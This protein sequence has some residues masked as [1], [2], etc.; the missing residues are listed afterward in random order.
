MSDIRLL[1]DQLINRIAAGEVVERPASVLKELMENS[2]DAGATRLEV[3][4]EN[5]GR[6]LVAV[7]D[8]GRGMGPDDLL[9]AVERHATSKLAEESDLLNID[10]LGF[11]GEALPSIGAVSR[12]TITS[13]DGGDG[14]GRRARISGGRLLGVDDVARD[15]GTTVEAAD[16]FFNVPARRKF[17]KSTATEAAHCLE[18]VQRFAI[19]RP[20]LRLIYRHNRQEMLST[21]P[22]EDER[23]RLARVLGRDTARSLIPFEGR[24]GVLE[25]R[26]WLGVPEMSRSR[27]G[28]VYLFVNGRP[29]RD[30]LLMRT[31]LASYQSRLP[32]GRYPAVVLFVSVD[33]REVDVNVH[34]AKAEV[35]FRQPNEIYQAAV[36]IMSRALSREMAPRPLRPPAYH[37]GPPR[38]EPL[39]GE[40]SPGFEWSGR[41]LPG[42]GY[43]VPARGNAAALPEV[44]VLP[45]ELRPADE[46][47]NV[48][49]LRPV[50]Q[51]FHSYILAQGPDELWVVDQHAAHERVLFER[52]AGELKAGGLS[53]QGLLI[54]ETVDL[55]PT[56][57]VLLSEI[58]EELGRFGF[59]VEPFG[60]GTY[61]IRATPGI[62]AGKDQAGV[63]QEIMDRAGADRPSAGLEK[64]EHE[65]LSALACQGAVKAGQALSF[66]EMDRLLEDLGRCDVPTHCPHGRPLIFSLERREIERRFH[67][68]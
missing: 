64:F 33:P 58:L 63:L 29:V 39:V 19:G 26:G 10:T 48:P 18:T 31:V 20:E 59:D 55:T 16:L 66:E 25:L 32:A 35:R 41:P 2:L 51:I 14:S 68:I 12:L 15:R 30:R 3:D 17:L 53:R 27:A 47:Q 44:T 60:G 24:T 67:R 38:S 6:R 8:N 23:A 7:K 52:L 65:L 28:A 9:L 37:S 11:R 5:G 61:V 36:D 49:G 45:S 54:P 43:P 46:I 62:L 50:G 4:I 13:A 22:K 56:Q 42:A 34:P 21:S 57:A 1:S 40:R